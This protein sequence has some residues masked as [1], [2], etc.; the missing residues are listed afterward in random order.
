MFSFERLNNLVGWAVWL[1]AALTYLLT[2]EPSASFWDCGEYI[3]CAYRLEVGHPPGAPFFMLMGRVFGLLGGHDASQAAR[4]INAMSA[5]CSAFSILFLFWSITRLGAK[6]YNGTTFN[7]PRQLAVL[8]AGLVGALAFTFSDTFWFNAVEGEV[9]AMSS[10]FTAIVFWAVLKWDEEDTRNPVGAQRWL[11]LISCLIGISI[12]VHLLSLLTIPAICFMIYFKK[13][14][15][16]R[17]GFLIAG[18]V[19]ISLLVFVQN[20]LIPKIVKFVSD[21]EV[22]FTNR[23]HMGFS[24][25]T[26]IYFLLL[27][28]SLACF[29][30]YT[31]S[32]KTFYYKTAQA[33]ALLFAA[34][35]IVAAPSGSGMALR[36]LLLGGLL[37]AV[38]RYRERRMVLHTVFLSFAT[39]L[40]GY[41]SFFVL[42]IRSQANTPMDEGDPENAA[43]MLSYLLR[44]Q[45]EEAPLLYGPYYNAP[46]RPRSE[47]GDGDPLYAKDVETGRYKIVSS[48]KHS[49]PKYEKA[50]CT[51][52]PRMYSSQQASHRSGY[53]Y[54]G[55]VAE[56][57][58]NKTVVNEHGESETQQVPDMTANLT[59]FFN[60][61]LG[62][63]YFRYLF[64]N[65]VGR[66]NDVQGMTGNNMEGNWMTGIKAIDDLRLDTD[67]SRVIHRDQR[68][69][70]RNSYYG[71]PLLLGVLGMVFHFRRRAADAW[72]TLCFFLM[73]GLAIILYLNQ[74]P[75]QVRERDYAYV[76][77]FYAYAIWI[78][79][80]LLYLF[81]LLTSKKVVAVTKRNVLLL[82]GLC[83]FVPAMMAAEGWDDHNRAQR[84]LSRATAINYLQSYAPNAILFTNGDCDTFPLWYAQEVEHIR[85]DVRVVCLSLL[86]T[87]WYARQM[88]RAAYESERLPFSIPEEKVEGDKLSYLIIDKRNPHPIELNAALNRAVHGDTL[89]D[90]EEDAPGLLPSNSLY[91]DVDTAAIARAGVVTGANRK[92]MST[93]M[94]WDLGNRNYILKND[95]LVLDL[96]ANCGWKRP[97]YFTTNAGEAC[98]GLRDYLQS[99]GITFRL[100]PIKQTNEE[101]QEGGRVNTDVM[102]T[103]IMNKFQWGGMNLPGVNLDENCLRMPA[104]LRMQM[105]LLAA[106]LIREGEKE[107][108]RRVLDKCLTEMPDATVP[109]DATLYNICTAYYQLGDVQKANALAEQLFTQFEG[110]LQIYNAQRPNKRT[111]YRAE[112]Q[113]A[114]SILE[115]LAG[116]AKHFGQH[117]LAAAFISRLTQVVPQEQTHVL[118]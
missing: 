99:E 95:L 66:Q 115:G 82:T 38:H 23:L 33:T 48:R 98:V 96:V 74:S 97:I 20:L 10:L 69:K 77:S 4:M 13:H 71:L 64:W 94:T 19:S 52:F 42:V 78:G 40:I 90:E 51:L 84:T 36:L 81:E 17:K 83:L 105:G 22:F 9:Y 60:Y 79:F 41:S 111:A 1:V 101:A 2:I 112:M 102:Y 56:H 113:Q 43:N 116:L 27:L 11:I 87:D 89:W 58:K 14:K 75:F 68:N 72:V 21:Y 49:L 61:Q 117:R 70:G 50:F 88:R 5:L 92:R 7:R 108:A 80:G 86:Q 118:D 93:R 109:F 103:N 37:Y 26:V 16:T 53:E 73:T 35:S 54:W 3:A 30:Y 8:G 100:V 28:T 39:L 110:D 29:I 114:Q 6:L 91:L 45:Y 65:F 76:G 47:F 32:N 106:A 15:A 63:M 44:E 12:G 34:L 62:Y 55:N 18:L 57:H 104:N 46:R 24:T 107:K 59:Y 85:T 31:A 67:T 25:G